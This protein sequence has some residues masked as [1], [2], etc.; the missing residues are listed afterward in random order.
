MKTITKKALTTKQGAFVAHVCNTR[1]LKIVHFCVLHKV[2]NPHAIPLHSNMLMY[3]YSALIGPRD[4]RP[5]P[6]VFIG[7]L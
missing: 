1:L 2:Q 4:A 6:P 5:A 7:S 3:L